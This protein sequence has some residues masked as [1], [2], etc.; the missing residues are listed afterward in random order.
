M[1][2]NHTL[3]EDLGT[4]IRIAPGRLRFRIRDIL[5]QLAERTAWIFVRRMSRCL[6]E[7]GACEI[8]SNSTRG[9]K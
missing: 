8:C 5:D 2:T 7:T 3:E 6:F 9:Y 1:L 4:N